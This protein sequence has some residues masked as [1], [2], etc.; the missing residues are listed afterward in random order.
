MGKGNSSVIEFITYLYIPAKCWNA[1][2]YGHF[3]EIISKTKTNFLFNMMNNSSMF[4]DQQQQPPPRRV[5][6]SQVPSSGGRQQNN[7][8]GFY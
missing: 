2:V 1:D 4:Q 3:N 7:Q 6:G 8:S 5:I